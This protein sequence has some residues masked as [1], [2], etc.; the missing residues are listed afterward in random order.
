MDCVGLSSLH[1]AFRAPKLHTALL[2]QSVCL[3]ISH[4]NSGC[5]LSLHLESPFFMAGF[6]SA[7]LSCSENLEGSSQVVCQITDCFAILACP[8]ICVLNM[9]NVHEK[10]NQKRTNLLQLLSFGEIQRLTCEVYYACSWW[11][12]ENLSSICA[13]VLLPD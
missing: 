1:C 8:L 7:G 13:N 2:E 9:I 6:M 3:N 5:H 4:K 11:G 12:S 10:C